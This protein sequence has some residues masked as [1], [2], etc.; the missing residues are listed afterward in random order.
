VAIPSIVQ[1]AL[2]LYAAFVVASWLT[3]LLGSELL[4]FFWPHLATIALQELGADSAAGV[5]V[6][7]I[8]GALVVALFAALVHRL[9]RQHHTWVTAGIVVAVAMASATVASFAVAFVMGWQYAA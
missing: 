3:S 5:V 7:Q 2:A 9:P 6:V 4:L 8:A 1:K